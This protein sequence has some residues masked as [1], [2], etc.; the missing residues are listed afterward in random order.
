ME[1]EHSFS[2]FFFSFSN[3]GVRHSFL[4]ICLVELVKLYLYFSGTFSNLVYRQSI[5]LVVS[6]FFYF[7]FLFSVAYA[8]MDLFYFIILASFSIFILLQEFQHVGLSGVS[9]SNF[10][11]SVSKC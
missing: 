6:G 8:F 7:L 9:C 3:F 5:L 2:L 11:I 10:G 1:Q 4:S